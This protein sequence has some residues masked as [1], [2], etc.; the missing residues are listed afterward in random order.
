MYTS[1]AMLKSRRVKVALVLLLLA[2]V[3]LSLPG[4]C[5]TD[6]SLLPNFSA[7]QSASLQ[8]NQKQQTQ[9]ED[10]CFCCCEHIIP[11]PHSELSVALVDQRDLFSLAER[12]PQVYVSTPYP[13]P[14]S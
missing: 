5:R 9:P 1:G 12:E 6:D 3:D 13:P 14:R 11:A 8:A 4:F 2:L 7:S 10:D